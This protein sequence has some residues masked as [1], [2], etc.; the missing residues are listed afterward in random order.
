[1]DQSSLPRCYKRKYFR[2]DPE[3]SL[4]PEK[5][6][7]WQ[8]LQT[9]ASETVQNPSVHV[10]LLIAANFLPA[11]EPTEFIESEAGGPYAY[12]TKL[13]WCIVGPVG[14]RNS[15]KE[16]MTCNRITV[17]EINS[18]TLANHHFQIKKEVKDFG[19]EEIFKK[20]YNQDFCE[21]KLVTLDQSVKQSCDSIIS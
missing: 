1:M 11:L 12:K 2:V 20:M 18:S 4:T 19:I 16:T 21:D 8:Y 7:R 13:G 14:E 5:L 15:G 6:R 17:R 10:G 9:I 3:E